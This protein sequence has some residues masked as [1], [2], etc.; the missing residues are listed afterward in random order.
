MVRRGVA[1]AL[2]VLAATL[3][4][5]AAGCGGDDVSNPQ[6]QTLGEFELTLELSNNT[7]AVADT[8]TAYVVVHNA[9]ASVLDDLNYAWKWGSTGGSGPPTA[10]MSRALVQPAKPGQLHVEVVVSDARH[11]VTLVADRMVPGA[12]ADGSRDMITIYEGPFLRGE[13]PDQTA[14]SSNT[15]QQTITLS[16]F[17]LARTE[18]TNAV[19]AEILNWA[20]ERDSVVE[21]GDGEGMGWAAVPSPTNYVLMD[22]TKSMLVWNGSGVSVPAGYELH[23]VTG[24]T[25]PGA[26]MLCN[27]RSAMDGFEPAYTFTPTTSLHVYDITC[28]FFK[29]GYRLPTE[30]EWEKAARGGSIL[31]GGANPLPDRRY[32]WGDEGPRVELAHGRQG[33]VRA[34]VSVLYNTVSQARGP[35]F[36][37]ALPVGSF[38]LGVG[39]YGH[40]DLLGNAAEWCWD[41]VD[42]GYYATAPADDPTGPAAETISPTVNDWKALRGDSWSRAYIPRMDAYTSEEGCGKRRW[43]PY[44]YAASDLGFRLARSER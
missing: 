15:P 18:M 16:R 34:N 11:A 37:G 39:P 19:C 42:L 7:P 17:S 25:W 40:L 12:T 21:I 5:F 44:P 6:A 1:V 30:A 20:A 26:A 38:P 36:S 33:S 28:D 31:P 29:N 8:V 4:A 41:W 32:P 9:D 10:G 14:F 27:W 35:I 2:T 22:L 24:V 43:A 13:R 23:P 3:L